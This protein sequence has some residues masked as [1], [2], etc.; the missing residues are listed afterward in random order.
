MDEL[1]I[2]P[3][4]IQDEF[5]V[6]KEGELFLTTFPNGDVPDGNMGG[7]GLYYRDTR[8]LSCLEHY[9]ENT[10]PVL[11]SASTRGSHFGQVE[12]TNIEMRSADGKVVPMQSL[13]LRLL[14]VMRGSFYQRLRLINYNVFP[15]TLHLRILMAADFRDIFEIRGTERARRGDLFFPVSTESCFILRYRGLDGIVRGTRVAFEP[16]PDDLKLE[17][18]R[19]LATFK[20]TLLPHQKQYLTWKITPLLNLDA[21]ESLECRN[22]R[23]VALSFFNTAVEQARDY[24]KWQTDC[25]TFSSNN[26]LFNQMMERTITDLRSLFT[27]YTEGTIVEAGIPWYAAPF[28]RDSLITSWQTLILNPDIARET[29]RYLKHYQGTE[30]DES[31]DEEPGKILHEL[32]RG[33]MAK[34]GEVLHT[35]YYGSVDAT[36]LFIIV[37][38]ELYAWT[39]DKDFLCEMQEALHKALMWAYHYGDMDGD[40]YIEYLRKAEGGL[41]NQGWKDSWNAI[42]DKNNALVSPPIALVEVQAYYYY[43]LV[44]ASRLLRELGDVTEA[45][46]AERKAR[47]L[48][49]Q[50]HRDYWVSDGEYY[51]LALD[52]N[53]NLITTVTSNMGHCLFAKIVDPDI[54]RKITDR[55]FQPDMFSGWG[56]RT[57]SKLE[58]AYNP[59][60][61]H[62][63]SVWPHDNAIIAAGLRNYG[64]LSQLE[65]LADS[66][67]NAALHFNY[68]RLPELFCGF[69]RRPIGGPVRYPVACDPQAWAVGCI[70]TLLQSLLGITCSPEGL[71]IKTPVLP[72][73]LREL[74]IKNL[75]V[76]NGIVDLGFARNR[77]RTYCYL[78]RKEGDA[79]V[80][81]EI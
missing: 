56:I 34:C 43:A 65:Q 42:V 45:E 32:R 58:K 54:A 25:T 38:G 17:V 77:G 64:L 4:D 41:T 68:Y 72:S 30:V 59:M 13:H 35:P 11:L 23:A 66:L 53:K 73:W 81:I 14:R 80:T 7:L 71:Q 50:F 52:G 24:R 67:Y 1:H 78:L 19:A 3:K 57:M 10:R 9:L 16:V 61:Y 31:R 27:S 74:N 36:L 33:E 44:V 63:G 60:S 37:L 49:D 76:G 26:D 12:L 2:E 18:D 5:E 29:L 69:T 20:I 28:G 55:L 40:G 46:R 39:G 6:L 48:R 22:S 15:V 51:G 75:R 70:F 21:G 79:R 47:A 8:F 62:N